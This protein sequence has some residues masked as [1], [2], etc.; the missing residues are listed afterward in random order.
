MESLV[1]FGAEPDDI[2]RAAVVAMVG[3]DVLGLAAEQ[4]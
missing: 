1:A 2:E 4:A 3:V